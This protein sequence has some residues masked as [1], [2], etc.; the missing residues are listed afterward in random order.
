MAEGD[1]VDDPGQISLRLHNAYPLHLHGDTH[2]KKGPF[3]RSGLRD[4]CGL[5][6]YIYPNSISLSSVAMVLFRDMRPARSGESNFGWQ[7]GGYGLRSTEPL[8][9]IQCDERT[10][11][12]LYVNALG[13]MIAGSGF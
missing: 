13:A 6:I 7:T 1:G 3:C 11:E 4:H 8:L 2:S 10:P 5:N 12:L 9:L